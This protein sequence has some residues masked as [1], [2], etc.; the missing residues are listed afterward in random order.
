MPR[1]KLKEARIQ[2][3]LSQ[4]AFADL[5]GAERKAVNY[6]ERGTQEP[7]DCYRQEIRKKLNNNDPDLFTNYPEGVYPPGCTISSATDICPQLDTSQ[8]LITPCQVTAN[9][10]ILE[11]TDP[12][13]FVIPG[14][15]KGFREFMELVRRQFIEALAKFGLTAS[16]GGLSLGLVSSPSVDP[17][18]YLSLVGASIG[19]WC[20]WLN[21]G[22]Y[23][24]LERVLLKNA[25]VLKR[26]ANTI[27]P[28]Q[29]MAAPL[30]VKAMIMQTILANLNFDYV[31]REIVCAEA[32]HCGQLSGNSRIL[33][34]AL[35]W[36]GGTYI[37]CYHQPQIA[38]P[39]L[40][41]AL[42][43]LDDE[44]S[45][46]RNG[47]QQRERSLLST[48]SLSRSAIYIDLS[49]AY[50]QDKDESNAKENES[51]ARMYAE[52]ARMTMP[53]YPEL[54]SLYPYIHYGLSELDQIEGMSLLYSAERTCNR[55][56]AQL[57]YDIFE[58]SISKQA[59]NQAYLGQAYI[60]RADA[61]R[62]L[63]DMNG[64]VEDLTEGFHIGD[65]IKSLKRL[66]Q[67]SG[68]ISNT[69]SEWKRET[70]MQKLHRDI[71]NAIQELQK[72]R[73]NAIVVARR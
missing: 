7:R 41:D 15:V 24:E 35:M 46:A 6:W 26:L 21:Q 65:E 17:E 38:I 29:S 55:R 51:N 12:S 2:A 39:I 14:S 72:D 20:Q 61:A 52:L 42:S 18:E 71:A 67:A 57:A 3:K 27:S 33:A 66:Y 49:V 4:S 10:A 54:D 68:V 32:V 73:S 31:G 5:V 53:D 45:L 28:F 22:N 16:F 58:K 37:Y 9:H 8:Q 25:P 40:H 23:G 63:G 1:Y 64:F 19:T 60:R 56:Y 34:L 11:S 70:A 44:A 36:Q 43:S 62:V 48:P 59:M 30:A 50:A 47:T 13:P 69:P